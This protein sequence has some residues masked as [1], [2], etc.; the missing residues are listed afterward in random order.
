MKEDIKD[1]N[2]SYTG[3]RQDVLRLLEA[4]D[5]ARVLD[6]GCATGELGYAIKKKFSSEVAGIEK[7]PHMAEKARQRLDLVV[8]GDVEEMDLASRFSEWYFTC[9]VFADTLEHL[10]DPLGVLRKASSCL[11]DGGAVIASI[12]NIS[13]YSAAINLVFRTRWPANERG[14]FDRTHLRFFTIKSIRELFREAGLTVTGIR[15]V[16]R[17][18]ERP[19]GLNKIAKYLSYILPRHLLTFQ[20][21]V[22]ARKEKKN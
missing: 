7:D 9:L 8:E 22:K 11:C 17:I 12:P 10:K 16:Y 19:H 3:P 2:P 5:A 14:L 20:Y 21:L 1:L 6:V 4:S 18:I 13:H 15:R